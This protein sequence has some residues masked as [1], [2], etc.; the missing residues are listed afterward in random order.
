MA[1]AM[2]MLAIASEVTGTL[3]LKA[4]D[5]FS[6]LW[7][8]IIVVCGYGVAFFMLSLTLKTLGLGPSYATWAGLGTVG[9]AL[10][11]WLIFG[12]RMGPLA[13]GG[14]AIVIAGIIVM[15]LGGTPE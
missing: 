5:G 6:R 10:G 14:M 12:E 2:L 3:A 8:S 1:W 11:A 7:P 13:I 15:H 9:A 4:S